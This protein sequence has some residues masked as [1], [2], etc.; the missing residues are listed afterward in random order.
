MSTSVLVFTR[1]LRVTDNPALAAA[2]SGG[3]VVPVFVVD[4][5]IV[6]RTAVNQAKCAFL[7][8]SL[9][10]LDAS[11]RTLGGRLVIRRGPWAHT[12]AE[13]AAR[14]QASQI[15]LAD[16]VSG[17]AARRLAKLRAL[18]RS[19]V[20]T[21]PGITIAGPAHPHPAGGGHY[22][23]FTPYYR[24]WLAAPRR[25]LAAIPAKAIL[26]AGAHANEVAKVAQLAELIEPG[27]RQFG[28]RQSSA[29]WQ[30]G[31]ESAGLA[32]L[33]S[34]AADQLA[35]YDRQRDRLAA[36]ATARISAYLHFGCL[37]PLAVATELA[38]RPGGESFVRQLAWRDFFCQLLKARPDA[39]HADYKPGGDRWRDDQD[40]LAAWQAGQT[41]YPGVDA[42]MR[43]L[44]AEGFMSNRARMIV[45]SFL[46]KDLYLDWRAG[47]AHFM[48]L[49][50]DADVACN[51]L[52][53]QWVAGTGTDRQPHRI[54]NPTLQSRRYDP[55]GSYISRYVPELAG[56]AAEEIHDPSPQSRRARH[57]PAPIVDHQA[58]AAAWRNR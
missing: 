7:L 46:T 38:S 12:V 45:A 55:D 2:A 14:T 52:N 13:L 10:D 6:A 37:S 36:E 51:Q 15:H 29:S 41:G 26:P 50:A 11:L 32:R 49:L 44:A 31:G 25:S 24:S 54:F 23:V 1:D 40:A 8:D 28:Q 5:A 43:Q 30:Q 17:Y 47:A 3:E 9:A 4:D 21:H 33:R 48:S 16:D 19:D 56:L 20:I 42:A 18:T 57:Y 39:A 58:A 34:W 53:W 35:G 22:Q 27:H